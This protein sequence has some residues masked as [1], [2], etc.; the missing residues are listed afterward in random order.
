MI[1][2]TYN[3]T[4]A[5][6]S[7]PLPRRRRQH[8]RASACRSWGWEEGREEGRGESGCGEWGKRG[9]EGGGGE[10]RVVRVARKRIRV[11]QGAEGEMCVLVFAL[12]STQNKKPSLF[13]C[14]KSR[15]CFGVL[16][17]FAF[18]GCPSLDRRPGDIPA[19]TPLRPPLSSWRGLGCGCPLSS[20]VSFYTHPQAFCTHNRLD[21][22]HRLPPVGDPLGP[23]RR[24][25]RF[26][27]ASCLAA[28]AI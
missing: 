19:G 12:P 27:H 22:D 25:S 3:R 14:P 7:P 6:A 26:A 21:S 13:P 28:I 24:P 9:N 20:V 15:P 1:L 23:G 11:L 4:S 10:V 16:L 5:A 8:E 2:R 18:D 17:C